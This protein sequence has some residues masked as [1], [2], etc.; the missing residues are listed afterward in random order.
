MTTGQE[1][2]PL[3]TVYG[4]SGKNIIN[5]S[6]INREKNILPPLHLI[7]QGFEHQSSLPPQ[8]LKNT[9]QKTLVI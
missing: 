4:C 6:L 5:K 3:E 1:K 9:F 8:P 2:N 7:C